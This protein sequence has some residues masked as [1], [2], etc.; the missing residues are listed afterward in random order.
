MKFLAKTELFIII[1]GQNFCSWQVYWYVN[2]YSQRF[3]KCKMEK[4]RTMRQLENAG[5]TKIKGLPDSLKVAEVT[6]LPTGEATKW[7]VKTVLHALS[8]S[9]S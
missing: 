1:K 7:G 5:N 8:C 2:Q 3:H 6:R 9:Q 4:K